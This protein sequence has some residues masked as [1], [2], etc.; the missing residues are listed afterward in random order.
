VRNVDI[1]R[2]TP[3]PEGLVADVSFISLVKALASL[4]GPTPAI[5]WALVLVKPQFEAD[6]SEIEPGG[7][8]RDE[9]V[10]TRTV[11]TVGD[12]LENHGLSVKA[13]VPSRLRGPAG[14]REFFISATRGGEAA[15]WRAA[16]PQTI[17]AVW[18][19]EK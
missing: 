17:H 12:F 19:K 7:V 10:V 4:L 9:V 2:W 13:V 3:P 8:V 14:N 1:T 16:V 18:R 15:A 6:P 5:Q 11:L